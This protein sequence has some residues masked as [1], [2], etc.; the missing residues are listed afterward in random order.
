MPLGNDLSQRKKRVHQSLRHPHSL[1]TLQVMT[2]RFYSTRRK[3][4]PL[5]AELPAQDTQTLARLL[6]CFG[7]ILL[8]GTSAYAQA[9]PES[10]DSAGSYQRQLT[11]YDSFIER[12]KGT[13]LAFEA[14][15][16]AARTALD[17][18]RFDK[19]LVYLR[20]LDEGLVE[21]GDFVLSL[22]ARAER[23]ES[24]WDSARTTWEKLLRDYPQSPL[25]DE[26]S[27]G[28]ADSH[29]AENDLTK[30]YKHY[31]GA[32][33]RF[34]KSDRVA[35]AKL[36]QAMIAEKQKRWSDAEFIYE[37]FY[38]HKPSHPLT[39]L[40]KKRLDR[41]LKMGFSNKPSISLRLERIDKLLSR[42]SLDKAQAD[43]DAME[44]E[45]LSGSQRLE[46]TARRA[47]LAYRQE[48]FLEAIAMFQ[49]LST[50]QGRGHYYQNQTWLARCY[51]TQGE[52]RK[53]VEVYG[54]L[55]SRYRG[56]GQGRK[57]QFM[58][59]WLAYN[60]GEH[61]L[62]VKLFAEFIK[63]YSSTSST[64]EAY[65]YLA[66]SAYR[67]GDL[68]AASRLYGK[69]RKKYP[70]SSLVQ[71]A[72]YWEGRIA[73]QMGDGKIALESYR[74]AI[75]RSPLNYY[76][77]LARQR[78]REL[79]KNP[80]TMRTGETIRLAAA[81]SG[82]A[83]DLL[84]SLQPEQE[85]LPEFGGMQPM[86]TISLPWG[87]SVFDWQSQAG[88]RALML[89]KFGY[90]EHA[91]ELVS[92]LDP[93]SGFTETDILLA[94]GTLLQSL[95][96]YSKAYRMAG[97]V[98][99]SKLRQDLDSDTEAYFRMSYPMAFRHALMKIS[100]EFG[101][102]PMLV[103]GVIRQESAFMTKARSWASAQGLMQIIPRTG[104]KIAEA[105]AL[106]DYNYGILRIPEVNIRFGSWYLKELL[107]KFHGHPILAVASYNAG[108]KAVARWV[109]LR[110]GL[111][112]DEFVE[113]IPYRE[114]RHY[115]K[116][117]LS[118]FAI[119]T[120]LYER[121]SLT[122]PENVPENYLDNIEF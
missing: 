95:G 87:G 112:T 37:D 49:M 46:Y 63:R 3:S 65:W 69:L 9:A 114:T 77:L 84:K 71:R 13:S 20:D 38:F 28:V 39:P 56:S 48:N 19:A 100:E 2:L 86:T 76:G 54:G 44:D 106:E 8:C 27:F 17:A 45:K 78:I 58:G 68:P 53:A 15:F 11:S 40:A 102:P 64:A 32:I 51:S 98:F 88:K 59:A 66:W 12:H 30:A 81:D 105:L 119:Y 50:K 97:R 10:A 104:T 22:R 103:L 120:E 36:N 34:S 29:Y 14:R 90:A 101:I 72:L 85:E 52:V 5:C 70:R 31:S 93:I 116:A 23:S 83:S 57:A 33:K 75:S 41:L 89:I 80:L 24:R 82:L 25:R 7:F 74:Q 94:R 118:N 67:L 16:L 113:E 109:K 79:Q 4:S 92:Q 96:D 42:R 43:L 60:G 21:I 91:A 62:A 110:A 121:K 115:V 107:R 1:G 99:K 122:I 26:A 117:V 47:I 55:A 61:Q 73:A 35:N 111:P 18:S 6:W 108:P